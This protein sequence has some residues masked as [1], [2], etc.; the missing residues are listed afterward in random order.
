MEHQL[1]NRAFTAQADKK[2]GGQVPPL[3]FNLMSLE[4]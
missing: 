4:F 3:K 2:R 1:N